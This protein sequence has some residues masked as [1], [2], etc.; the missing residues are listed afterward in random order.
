MHAVGFN[1]R[2]RQKMGS[3]C[4]WALEDVK[5]VVYDGLARGF[6]ILWLG[7]IFGTFSGVTILLEG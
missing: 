2:V 5:T 6:P 7:Y 3:G 4:Y 1:A